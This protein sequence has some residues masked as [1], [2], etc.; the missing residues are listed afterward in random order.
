MGLEG[1]MLIGGNVS[2]DAERDE[3]E[4]VKQRRRK[5]INNNLVKQVRKQ[6]L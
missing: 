4:G 2:K 3:A 6:R 1:L 5:I